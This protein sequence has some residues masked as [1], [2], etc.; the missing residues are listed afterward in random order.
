ME[1]KEGF[2]HGGMFHADDVF[3]TALL[4]ILWPDIKIKRGFVV[5]KDFSGIVYDIGGGEF[6]HHQS[7]KR[8]RENQVPY[9]AFGL[10]WERFGTEILGEEDAREF[11]LAFVQPL[12]IS[13]NTGK[14]NLIA[15]LIADYNPAW[16]ENEESDT[17]FWNAV[18]FAKSILQNRFRSIRAQRKAYSIVREQAL[19]CMTGI[20][21]LDT[22]LPWKSAVYDLPIYYVIYP[23]KRGGYNVQAV[24]KKMDSPELKYPFPQ[25]WCGASRDALENLT[26]IEEI[27]F[28]HESG[29]LCAVRTLEAAEKLAGIMM[30]KVGE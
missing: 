25:A 2:T 13:D 10:L 14:E 11:D 5:P 1:Y 8:L 26:G 21:I 3:A 19:K 12:D 20:L 23:S 22:G 24:P 18:E 16:N 7:N 27:E 30:E 6:D 17:C 9:A 28:C 4:K 29:F 15:T